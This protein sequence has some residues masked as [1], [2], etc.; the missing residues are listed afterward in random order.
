MVANNINVWKRTA[1]FSRWESNGGG[2]EGME[3][4][5]MKVARN[6]KDWSYG[7]RK[8]G[9]RLKEKGKGG[10]KCHWALVVFV[11]CYIVSAFITVN[12]K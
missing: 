8:S 3:E 2:M 1:K 11:G 9:G 12:A 5:S 6:R 7:A 10:K 4:N